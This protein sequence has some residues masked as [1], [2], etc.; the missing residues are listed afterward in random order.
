MTLDDEQIVSQAYQ[1]RAAGRYRAGHQLP[2]R[3]PDLLTTTNVK[4]RP[5]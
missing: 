5:R 1:P 4:G 2:A 3:H